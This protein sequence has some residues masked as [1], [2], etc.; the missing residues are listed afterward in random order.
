MRFESAADIKASPES[1]W[2]AIHDPTEW[3][4]WISSVK[5][6]DQLTDGPLGMG[7]KVRVTVRSG[8]TVTL[9]M[10]ITQF[11]PGESVVMEGRVLATRLTRWY[12]LEG[13]NGGHTR[14][15]AG[16]QVS[17]LL[18]WFVARSGQR[19]SEEIT[20]SFKKRVEG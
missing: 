19:L 10:T 16:G 1:V 17:G 11:V 5:K 8:F 14:A 4:L 13:T 18:S 7:T 3:P 15:V 9:L 2:S 6:V 20:R 12:R